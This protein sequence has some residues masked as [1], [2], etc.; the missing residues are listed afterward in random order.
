MNSLKFGYNVN[1]DIFIN[2]Y[3][4][5][6]P[7]INDEEE[8]YFLLSSLNSIHINVICRGIIKYS[9]FNDGMHKTYYIQLLN[10]EDPI[11]LLDKYYHNNKNV[12]YHHN[13]KTGNISQIVNVHGK[14]HYLTDKTNKQF[15]QKNLFKIDCFFVRRDLIEII[16]LR[17]EYSITIQKL[18]QKQINELN[19]FI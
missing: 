15:Y 8:C 17:R 19:S 16:S 11:S 13:N 2:L 7:I 4:D 18:L 3:S 5:D 9:T 1:N 6:N 12:L 14:I 10:F